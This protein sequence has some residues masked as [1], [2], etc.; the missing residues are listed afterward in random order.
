MMGKLREGNQFILQIRWQFVVTFEHGNCLHFIQ[1][2]GYSACLWVDPLSWV[3]S[4]SWVFQRMHC[5][6]PYC[7]PPCQVNAAKS[8]V[9]FLDVQRD[10]WKF[11]YATK[12]TFESVLW[13]IYLQHSKNF[14]WVSCHRCGTHHG[15][16]SMRLFLSTSAHH[17]GISLRNKFSN[18][19]SVC[20]NDRLSCSR[21]RIT[22]LTF[23]W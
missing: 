17:P 12:T 21:H 23:D 22:S 16:P 9:V 8:F 3:M 19:R 11:T 7:V 13:L 14:F 10:F 20:L 2:I 15:P 6:M 5:L 4:L 18:L 1:W